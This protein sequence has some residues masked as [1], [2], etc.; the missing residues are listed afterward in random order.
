MFGCGGRKKRRADVP[1]SP[2]L[3]KEGGHHMV[4]SDATSIKRGSFNPLSYALHVRENDSDIAANRM[5]V[6]WGY[7]IAATNDLRG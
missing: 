4:T 6:G 3:R 1:P 2:P 7:D 5:L